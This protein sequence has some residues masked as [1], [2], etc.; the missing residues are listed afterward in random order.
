[1]PTPD[2]AYGNRPN[3]PSPTH[4]S[5]VC[6]AKLLA[7]AAARDEMARLLAATRIAQ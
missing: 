3:H 4:T 2:L 7:Q 1:M 6:L 5:V